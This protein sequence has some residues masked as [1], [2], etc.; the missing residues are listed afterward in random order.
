MNYR[1]VPAQPVRERKTPPAEQPHHRI[2]V[3]MEVEIPGFVSSPVCA[4]IITHS[5][6]LCNRRHG[7]QP[8]FTHMSDKLRLTRLA[9]RTIIA[10]PPYTLRRDA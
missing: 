4:L 2:L 5:R 6:P 9:E 1:P 3:A 10:T 8:E 7:F